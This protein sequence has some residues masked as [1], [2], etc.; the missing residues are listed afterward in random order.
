MPVYDVVAVQTQY[1]VPPESILVVFLLAPSGKIYFVSQIHFMF[2]SGTYNSVLKFDTQWVHRD[3]LFR[4]QYS[5]ARVK[6]T[7]PVKE[8]LPSQSIGKWHIQYENTNPGSS[9]IFVYGYNG[10]EVF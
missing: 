5:G 7:I 1:S 8:Y 10:Y 2:D 6:V 4:Y 9:A 3:D